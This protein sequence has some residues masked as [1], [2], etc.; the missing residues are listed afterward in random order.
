LGPTV[1]FT[2]D[3]ISFFLSAVCIAMTVVMMGAGAMNAVGLLVL[4]HS[5]GLDETAFGYLSP[6][7]TFFSLL[8]AVLVG[9]AARKLKRVHL[10]V[11]VGLAF[12]TLSM[13]LYA[14]AQNIWWIVA[15]LPLMGVANV[16][17]TLGAG[18]TTQRLVPDHLMGRVNAVLG[19]PVTASILLSAGVAGV[20]A[21]YTEPRLIMVA[22]AVLI[23]LGAVSAY[24]GLWEV[25]AIEIPPAA[26]AG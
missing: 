3:A 25:P 22:A 23:G 20:V 15:A 17:L 24:L 19:M 13:T 14:A 10:L 26:A 8:S 5:L 1:S 11:P 12:A 21:R 18:T 4:K 9:S 6:L 2:I 16:V 7:Q